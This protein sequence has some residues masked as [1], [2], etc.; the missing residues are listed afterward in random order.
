M[1]TGHRAKTST[2]APRAGI[3]LIPLHHTCP[4]SCTHGTRTAIGQHVDDH[5]FTS[6]PKEVPTRLSEPSQRVSRAVIAAASPGVDS[7]SPSDRSTQRPLVTD[8]A[9]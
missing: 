6:E 5:I 3:G 2:F 1:Q 7:G 4:L 8:V 9:V